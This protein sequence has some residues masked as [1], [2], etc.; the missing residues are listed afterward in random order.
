MQINTLSI[1][2]FKGVQ[3]PR[4][5]TF[6]DLNN[7]SGENFQGKTTIGEAIVWAIYGIDLSGN[8]K[9]FDR[10]LNNESKKAKVSMT[11]TIQGKEYSLERSRKGSNTV[12]TLDGLESKQG[13]IEKLVPAK[14]IFLSIFT[15]NYFPGL[16]NAEARTLLMK[17]LPAIKPED[18]TKDMTEQQQTL[19]SVMTLTNVTNAMKETREEIKRTESEITRNLGKMEVLKKTA[20]QEIEQ[21]K[22][23]SKA[24]E[25]EALKKELL[26]VQFNGSNDKKKLEQELHGLGKSYNDLTAKINEYKNKEYAPGSTC[27]CCG[28]VIAEE[29]ITNLQQKD[30]EVIQGLEQEAESLKNKGWELKNQIAEFEPSAEDKEKVAKLQ[31]EI[32]EL[33]KEYDEMV[34]H[35]ASVKAQEKA[36]DNAF[37]EMKEVEEKNNQLQ[38]DVFELEQTIEALKEYNQIYAERQNQQLQQHF[39]KVSIRLNKVVKSTGELKPDFEILYDNKEYRTLSYSEQIRAGLEIANVFRV[40]GGFNCPT[41]I[42]NAESITHYNVP[43]CQLFT[44]SVVPNQELKLEVVEYERANV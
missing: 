12:I 44:A 13:E 6:S 16:A 17:Q 8:T 7:I 2:G 18:I 4:N 22:E 14:E 40:L 28:Q 33:Q 42:D 24:D 39:D 41:F 30:Q 11:F 38:N 26:D 34:E 23:F 43:E 29:H 19:L 20:H 27:D 35:N 1:E 37:N 36:K 3:T 31:A 32:S 5:Y 9:S 25:L 10:L 21:P 15:Q